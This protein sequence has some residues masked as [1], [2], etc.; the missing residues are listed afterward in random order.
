MHFREFESMWDATEPETYLPFHQGGLDGKINPYG[1]LYIVSI[2]DAQ[3]SIL[4][5]DRA[6]RTANLVNLENSTYHPY[7][8]QIESAPYSSSG[9]VYFDG[10]F[11]EVPSGNIQGPMEYHSLAHNQVFSFIMQINL[12]NSLSM[13]SQLY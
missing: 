7:G 12:M 5:A 6:A 11:P 10:R 13:R 2:N 1:L 4:S 9:I 3:V 8:I